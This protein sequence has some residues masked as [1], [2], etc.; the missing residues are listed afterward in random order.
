MVTG[1]HSV[2]TQRVEQRLGRRFK[3]VARNQGKSEDR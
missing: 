3:G 2:T 1:C